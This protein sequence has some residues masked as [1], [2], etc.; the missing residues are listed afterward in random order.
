MAR[1]SIV[2]E[3]GYDDLERWLCVLQFMIK[4][5][6]SQIMQGADAFDIWFMV[7]VVRTKTMSLEIVQSEET[8]ISLEWWH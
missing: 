7:A 3:P 5:P 6:H 4:V 2:R 8:V 1:T